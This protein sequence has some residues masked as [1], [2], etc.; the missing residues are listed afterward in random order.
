MAFTSCTSSGDVPAEP[1]H[2]YRVKAQVLGR[3]SHSHHS[4]QVPEEEGDK[5]LLTCL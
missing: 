3:A 5:D 1:G 2:L 4:W